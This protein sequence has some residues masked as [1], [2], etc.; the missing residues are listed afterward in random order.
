MYGV[1]RPCAS[2]GSGGGNFNLTSSNWGYNS[3]NNY[4]PSYDFNNY[5]YSSPIRATPNYSYNENVLII[6][7]QLHLIKIDLVLGITIIIIE[8]IISKEMIIPIL[9]IEVLINII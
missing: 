6:Q 5:R 8:L 7:G 1:R 2:C 3:L 4:S 9:L